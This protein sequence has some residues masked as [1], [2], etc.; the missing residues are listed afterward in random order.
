M[1]AALSDHPL[2][3]LGGVTGVLDALIEGQDL[4]VDDAE[5]VMDHVFDG[6]VDPI[7]VGGLLV[8]WRAKGE[9]ADELT[10]M[11]R[12]M[13][14]HATPVEL[15]QPAMDI[16]G[17][18]GDGTHS[19]NVSTMAALVVA[20]AGVAVCKHGNR[21]ASSLVGTAD[22]L[23]ALGVGIEAGPEVVARSVETAGIG[24]CFAPSF[25]PA[26]R[27][28]GPVR[29]TLGVRTA[30]NL[31][32]PLSNPSRPRHL[33][34]GT[35]DASAAE[36]MAMVLGANGVDRAWV[37]HSSDGYDEL[38]ISAPSDVVE[39]VGDSSGAYELSSWTL[40]PAS[41]GFEP[42]DPAEVRGG[43]VAFNA[44]VVRSVLAGGH[45]A[46]RELVSLN[47]AA[48]LVIVGR[49]SSLEEGLELSGASI[50]TGS[51]SAALEGLIAATS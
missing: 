1:D 13:V 42:V 22:V 3:R 32:G 47:A 40:D 16:V 46:V 51:A 38:S 36:K 29:R 10:G 28:V 9:T 12:S 49:A 15:S 33:L 26:M 21:A 23:E 34:I 50:D 5:L 7:V 25:H 48:A 11:V 4:S 39:V 35:A 45:G 6:V 8:A 20:G 37:V 43:D 18:G 30:F 31:L 2:A 17:T 44:A 19:V 41:L 27:F 14:A 24:F